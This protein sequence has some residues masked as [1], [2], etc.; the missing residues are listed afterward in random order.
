MAAPFDQ[1]LT[2]ARWLALQTEAEIIDPPPPV[3]LRRWAVD[4]IVFAEGPR[5]GG[6]YIAEDFPFFDRILEALSPDH[7]CR[8]VSLRKGAQ[9]GGTVLA[10]IF[11]AGSTDMDPAN[12]L[13]THPTEPNA[14]RWMRMKFKPFLRGIERLRAIFAGERTKDASA[15]GFYIERKDGRATIQLAGAASPSSL[16][17]I[18]VKR[19]V[20]DDLAKWDDDNG[21]GDPEGQADS[22]SKAFDDAKI[23]KNS[24]PLVAD[25]CRITKLVKSG[26]DERYHGACP[27]CGQIHELDWESFRANLES[28]ADPDDCYFTCPNC[29]G[30]IHEHH[31]AKFTAPARGAKWVAKHPERARYHV[32]FSLPSY[33]SPLSRWGEMAHKWV[34][35]KGDPNS[36]Q[37]FFNDYLGLAYNRAGEAPPAE[38][39][40]KRAEESGHAKGIIP[41]GFPLFTLGIDCQG[42]RVEVQAV[43]FGPNRRRAVVDYTVVAGNITETETRAELD[44][45]VTR[46]WP[47]EAGQRITPDI[48]AID[49]NAYT[50]DVYEWAKKY[51]RSQVIMVRG[52]FPDTAE[53]IAPVR[54][55]SEG[56]GK[57]KR[58]RTFGNRFFNVGVSVLKSTLYEFLKRT[59]PL[60]RGFVAFARGLGSEY[61]EQLCAETRKEI[62]TSGGRKVWRWT[63]KPNKANEALDT[64]NYA[65]AGATLKGWTR[66]DDEAWEI[67]F[68]EREQ[69]PTNPGEQLDMEHMLLTAPPKSTNPTPPETA[70]PADKPTRDKLLDRLA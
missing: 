18:S 51:P 26:S 47:N 32:S 6:R 57:R 9:L 48:V 30:H 65:E 25:N 61:F 10:M 16:S 67:L 56:K 13:Y 12:F 70:K 1:H 24:T 50:D 23:F 33:L 36:E 44:K 34:A 54:R 37:S 38:I 28:G 45:I 52:V 8:I 43:A 69:P 4:N 40:H 7:P 2:D 35:A 59:D 39:L 63:P 17:E 66:W 46:A 49:G 60:H 53:I 64:M 58:T 11:S 14:R 42:D 31:R 22:R 3:D 5:A 19:Q 20:Q 55:D 29:N 68:A 62:T 27:H 41:R 15:T 21:A